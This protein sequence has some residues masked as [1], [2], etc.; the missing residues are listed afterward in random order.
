MLIKSVNSIGPSWVGGARQDVL[1]LTNNDNV[2]G[3]SAASSFSVVTV[4]SPAF[5]GG[6]STLDISTFV[7][8]ITMEVDLQCKRLLSVCNDL[9]I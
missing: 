5:D 6:Q 2:W 7:E 3:M 8:G 4:D 9:A 1:M